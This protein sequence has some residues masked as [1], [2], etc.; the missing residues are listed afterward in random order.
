MQASPNRW[1]MRV[2]LLGAG[3]LAVCL[4]G[5]L[6]DVRCEAA[7]DSARPN[8]LFIVIDNVGYGDLGCY[9][10]RV[11]RTPNIDRLAGEGVRLTQFYVGS[12]SCTPS[13]GALL[14]GRHPVRNGLNWQLKPEEQL[15]IGLPHDE[16]IIPGYLKPLGY[17]TAAFGKWNIGFG[18]G[19][20]P[21]E[22]GFDEFFGHASG[23]IDYYAHD[24]N[25]RLDTYRGTENVRV[26][27]YST[28][29]FADGA[30]NFIRAHAKEPWFVYLPFNAAHEPNDRNTPPGEKTEWQVPGKYP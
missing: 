3:V 13:R 21:T 28:D 17:A 14:T 23:N 2:W 27:G 26:E 30:C 12:P 24:Y 19:G 1:A 8:I 9:G 20:R 6:T 5:L 22:R 18:P 7:A 25:G 10:N 16:R 11:I 29:L 4:F 15:G